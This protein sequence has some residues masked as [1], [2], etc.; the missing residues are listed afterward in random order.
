MQP[1]TV[2]ATG[3][4]KGEIGTP[5]ELTQRVPVLGSMNVYENQDGGR[6]RGSASSID[7]RGLGGQHTLMLLNGRRLPAYGLAFGGLTFSNVNNLPLAAVE[8]VEILR[9]GAAPPTAR[10]RPRAS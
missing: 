10:M 5:F 3:V 8:R 6:V 9:D 7:L 4:E 2:L 1:V